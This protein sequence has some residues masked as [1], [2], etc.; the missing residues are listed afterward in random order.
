MMRETRDFA[1]HLWREMAEGSDPETVADP[2]S[3][4]SGGENGS[5][6]ATEVPVTTAGQPEAAA[7]DPVG[8]EQPGPPSENESIKEIK[9]ED[10]ANAGESE[11]S[12]SSADAADGAKD[13]SPK[14]GASPKDANLKDGA[15]AP[16][17]LAATPTVTQA[18]EAGQQKSSE[19]PSN[20]NKNTEGIE[21]EQKDNAKESKGPEDNSKT[22]DGKT[23]V[24][25]KFSRKRTRALLE[26]LPSE[27][28]EELHTFQVIFR[29]CVAAIVGSH[30]I[31]ASEDAFSEICALAEVYMDTLFGKLHQLTQI[32]RRSQP[33][34]ADVALLLRFT[35]ISLSELEDERKLGSAR[36][37]DSLNSLRLNADEEPPDELEKLM[38]EDP[39]LR[40]IVPSRAQRG[41]YVPAWMPA[42]PPDHTF[43]ATPQ[44]PERVSDPRRLR[45]L[46]VEEGRLAESA[47]QRLFDSRAAVMAQL[48]KD[49]GQQDGVVDE[50][51]STPKANGVAGHDDDH[52]DDND[53]GN[54]SS[55]LSSVDDNDPIIRDDYVM[56]GTDE[57]KHHKKPRISLRLSIAGR[58]VPPLASRKPQDL[59]S[60][61]LD[62]VAYARERLAAR[63]ERL[64]K[65]VGSHR[66]RPDVSQRSVETEFAT[67]KRFL[68]DGVHDHHR[69]DYI[70]A[71]DKDRYN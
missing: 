12:K 48:S 53:N 22:S 17:D 9:Q 8:A 40:K 28:T 58:P 25:R 42:F 39:E 52:D 1:T 10:N 62:V 27:D 41:S 68:T 70:I 50:V 34:I 64:K 44:Y 5:S 13:A 3:Q 23:P 56:G 21:G 20:D 45:E 7:S 63:E 71:W 47:L 29:R 51:G 66:E 16:E 55:D 67:V 38:V 59:N 35:G 14:D 31:V 33:S 6:G 30:E 60:D 19:E 61:S 43:K 69:P 65:L 37:L 4:V 32:Q 18:P 54:D 15:A 24:K 49:D 36:M 26:M 2:A 46:I 11:K 57:A